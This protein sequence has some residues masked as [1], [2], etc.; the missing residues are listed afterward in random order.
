MTRRL[1]LVGGGHAHAVLLRAWAGQRLP[2]GVTATLLSPSHQAP[3]S[4][5]V[6]GWLAG[7]YR[8]DD[9]CIDLRALAAAAGVGWR[10]GEL[11]DLDAAAR[12]LHLADGSTEHYDLLSLNVGSTLSP[13]DWPGVRMLALRPLSALQAAWGTVLAESPPSSVLTVGGGAAGVEAT[14]AIIASLRQRHPLWQAPG[15][16]VTR[17]KVLLE[18]FPPRAQRA[19]FDALARAGV[20]V[21]CS[22]DADPTM[23]PPRTLVLWA[24]GAA[25]HPWQRRSALAQDAGGFIRTGATLCSTSHA[26]VF[27]SGDCASLPQ[28]LPKAGVFAV[29]QGPLLARNLRAALEGR[30]LDAFTQNGEALALLST[31]DGHAIAARGVW[32][33]AGP[34]IGKLLWRWKDY[35]DR[36]FVRGPG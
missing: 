19:A 24:A 27:A 31:A 3:Y 30:P 2:A 1:W 25:S 4:G 5:M 18:G 14:L 12:Q 10:D 13:P 17:S 33:A 7:H 35:I 36:A 15:R 16:L 34:R 22:T 28:P 9:I 8:F 6:P 20:A 21:Q 26:D 32:S 29:R 11:R 23:A